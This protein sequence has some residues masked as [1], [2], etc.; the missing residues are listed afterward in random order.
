MDIIFTIS[1]G[2][3][4]RL[5]NAVCGTWAEEKVPS[6]ALAKEIIRGW[7]LT[8]I[9]EYEDDNARKL[10]MESVIVPNDLIT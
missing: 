6:A 10:A 9:K 7:L 8:I 5:V 3:K 4:N 1:D 2:S